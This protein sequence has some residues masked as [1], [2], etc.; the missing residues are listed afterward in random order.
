M[1]HSLILVKHAPVT[2]DPTVQREL[3]HLSKEG[4]RCCL[5]LAKTLAGY[6]PTVLIASSVGNAQETAR[7]VASVLLLPVTVAENIHENDRRGLPVVSASLFRKRMAMFFNE[8][9]ERIMGM[10]SAH[11][12]QQ[13]FCQAIDRL[14][15]EHENETIVVI[16]HGTVISLFAA[17]YNALEP[18]PFWQ[19]LEQ[20]SLAV[21]D[22]PG[23]QLR[24]TITKVR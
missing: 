7:H 6:A 12:A 9:E 18:F 5:P 22:L 4:I 23:Y 1:S 2:I 14:V 16:A 19:Q 17:A 11:E 15:A 24:E 8:A 10:E 21:F 3:W 20:P 13:R